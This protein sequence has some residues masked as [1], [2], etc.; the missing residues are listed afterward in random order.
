MTFFS[1]IEMQERKWNHLVKKFL[2]PGAQLVGRS[3][4]STQRR[5]YRKA[6]SI[7]KIVLSPET[8]YKNTAQQEYLILR[9]IS[10]IDCVPKPLFFET[11]G[12]VSVIALQEYRGEQIGQFGDAVS[13]YKASILA[14][15]KALLSLNRNGLRHGDLHKD[16][17]IFLSDGT[18][19]ILDYDQA[20]FTTPLKA[21]LGD[22]FGIG[23][24]PA[25]RCALRFLLQLLLSKLPSPIRSYLRLGALVR[26]RRFRAG[27][28]KLK[29]SKTGA[30]LSDIWNQAIVSAA[31]SP[32][33]RKS[34]YSLVYEGCIYQGERPWEV[35]WAPICNGI[36]FKGKRLLE[37][38]CNLGLLSCYALHAGALPGGIGVDHDPNI[39]K[40]AKEFARF[41][42]V[43]VHFCILD[44]DEDHCWEDKIATEEFDIVSACSILQWVKDKNRMLS[45][46]SR[47]PEVLYE[48][49]DPMVNE[50]ARLKRAGFSS[51]SILTIS[52]R[53]RAVLL[54]QKDKISWSQAN[55][56]GF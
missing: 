10:H 45:F 39:I 28:P 12:P 16:N 23:E 21:F 26:R 42:G 47:F 38:G 9:H 24:F 11:F 4:S 50:I 49:H 32:G 29:A 27:R 46:L 33:D 55:H 44:F 31:N 56:D 52:E 51:I 48:G 54:A 15:I 5:V 34:Y 13:K 43:D 3:A 19:K 1:V 40:A 14:V 20:V 18:T 36:R 17:L 2:G 37:L 25:K 8:H 22:F 6:D 53:G 7:F 35:R 41:A 30:D